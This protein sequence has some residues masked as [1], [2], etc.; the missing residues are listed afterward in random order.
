MTESLWLQLQPAS[1]Q[2]QGLLG[3]EHKLEEVNP[4]RW[5]FLVKGGLAS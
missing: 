3:L 1:G 5:R 4:A 2:L